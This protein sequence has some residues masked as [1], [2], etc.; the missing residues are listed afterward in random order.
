MKFKLKNTNDTKLCIELNYI[1]LFEAKS[2]TYLDFKIYREYFPADMWL[3][4]KRVLN[5]F[6]ELEK[7]LLNMNRKLFEEITYAK[8]YFLKLLMTYFLK[9]TSFTYKNIYKTKEEINLKKK[10][11]III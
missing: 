10:Q 8:Y 4:S 7:Y 1:L 2:Y 5:I 6:D 9:E 3:N 11:I